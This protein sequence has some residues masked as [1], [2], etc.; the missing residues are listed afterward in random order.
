MTTWEKMY[1]PAIAKGMSITFGHMFKKKPT[2]NY[3]EKKRPFSPVFRG[4]HVLNRDEE[5]RER[6][7]L[8]GHG[9]MPQGL[10]TCPPDVRAQ[11]RPLRRMT[12]RQGL[13]AQTMTLS[14]QKK[15]GR[16]D[17]LDAD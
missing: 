4:L 17:L 6:C 13:I 8:P 7:A 15:R 5:G 12:E 3:P 16:I 11:S 14:E 9:Q 2:V 10:E 1:I